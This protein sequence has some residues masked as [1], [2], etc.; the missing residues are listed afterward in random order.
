MKEPC[1]CGALDCVRCHGE[2]AR[3][4]GWC[5]ECTYSDECGETTSP[6]DDECQMKCDAD[7]AEVN[8][9]EARMEARADRRRDGWED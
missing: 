5:D 9:Y 4:Y 2:S 8:A 6:G 3:Y 7:N 1:Y